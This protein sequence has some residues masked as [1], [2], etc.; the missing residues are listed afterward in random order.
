[1]I[2]SR[3][4]TITNISKYYCVNSNTLN[5]YYKKKI[6][7]FTSWTQKEHAEEY[8]VFPEN[9]GPLLSIDEVALSKGELY[10]FVTNKAGHGKKG[11]IVAVIASTKADDIQRV[12]EKL[13]ITLRESVQEITLDMAKNMEAGV[14]QSFPNAILVT[15]RFHVVRLAIEALQHIRV[16]LRWEE[17]DLENLRLANIRKAKKDY[18]KAI[19]TCMDDTKKIKR[20][21]N[22]FQK[23]I[24]RNQSIT[25]ENGDSPKQLL[26][27][28]RYILAKK[29]E[30]WTL[31]QKER[32][33]I[34]FK[35]YPILE[36]AYHEVMAFR[37]IYEEKNKDKAQ[38][39]L[40][41][42]IKKIHEKEMKEFYTVANT[43][44]NNF[45]NIL[46]FFNNRNTNA[47]AESFNSKIKLFRANQR[48]VKD[49]K[50]FLFRLSKLFA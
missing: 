42:W 11:T 49:T 2:E 4:D 19:K 13:D 41:N 25:L 46:N 17:M 45:E 44:E 8:L 22:K 26:A 39:K 15:D 10:T 35:Q 12:L 36:T 18:E 14:K 50:F 28:S 29:E 32:A 47:N 40:E 16:K 31:N 5:K 43:V 30:L 7:G 24:N 23:T 38:I 34:L 48:G 20:I 1:V 9:I 37:N 27:R 33:N 3:E 21:E 6:S